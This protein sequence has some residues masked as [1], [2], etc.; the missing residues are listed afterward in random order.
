[1]SDGVNDIAKVFHALGDSTRRQMV[2]RLGT[3]P[4]SLSRLA[5]PFDMTLTAVAQHLA[6]LEAAGLVVTEKIGRTR[7]AQVGKAG[8]AV[9]EAWMKAQRTPWEVR[10]DALGDI[11]DEDPAE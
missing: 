5:E 9:I 3:G 10:L 2:E 1:M 4:M 7:T 8:F 6:I 11:L